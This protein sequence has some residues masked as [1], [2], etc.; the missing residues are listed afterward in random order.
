MKKDAHLFT[1]HA[2]HFIQS[3]R[4][5]AWF[6]TINRLAGPKYRLLFLPDQNLSRISK[7]RIN[8]ILGQ[9]IC[10]GHVE[11][12]PSN[13]GEEPLELNS[14]MVKGL[15][16]HCRTT[17]RVPAVAGLV[18]AHN[19]IEVTEPLADGQWGCVYLLL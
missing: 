7:C 16:S 2:L 19:W 1:N 15:L 12:P 6:C 4:I 5:G 10:P 18:S 3:V 17:V 9:T 8:S 11:P 13:R 14:N